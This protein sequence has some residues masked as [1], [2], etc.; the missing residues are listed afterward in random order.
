[1][2]D[3]KPNGDEHNGEEEWQR[4]RRRILEMRVEE[5]SDFVGLRGVLEHGR[6]SEAHEHEHGSGA[7]S[8]SHRP[9]GNPVVDFLAAILHPPAPSHPD[10]PVITQSQRDVYRTMA[11][12]SAATR[13]PTDGGSVPNAFPARPGKPTYR[14]KK[15]VRPK[16]VTYGDIVTIYGSNLHGIRRITV[17]GAKAPIVRRASDELR[18]MVPE[19]A[20]DGLVVIDGDV[21]PRLALELSDDADLSREGKQREAV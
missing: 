5:L 15:P 19:D 10:T 11:N 13:R 6:R 18:F 17:G 20:E 7:S 16:T 21:E 8:S 2:S 3:D 14:D 4:L 12:I 9:A 1:M